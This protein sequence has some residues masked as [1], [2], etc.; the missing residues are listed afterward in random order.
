MSTPVPYTALRELASLDTCV[1]ADAIEYFDVRLRNEGYSN[2][3]NLHCHF[4][5][6]APMV[7]Y[8]ITVQVRSGNP[9]INGAAYPWRI[10]WWSE[11]DAFPS[12][13]VLVIEDLDRRP[14]IGSFVGEVHGA[15]LQALGCVGII[16]NGAVRS[17]DAIERTGL[18]LF[19]QSVSPSHAYA[20]VVNFGTPVE[21][22]G[23]RVHPGDLLHGDRNGIVRVPVHV[24][25]EIPA[26]AAAKRARDR[27]IIAFCRSA[28]FSRGALADM[29]RETRG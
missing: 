18:Q 26:F 17:L 19:S 7:G 21:V 16:T 10:D 9:P 28:N 1:V 3:E 14:G 4:P 24:A 8:A 23:L 20:H 13:H 25:P 2:L 27:E 15:I 22:A 12:P 29:L 6:Q 5:D 11:L